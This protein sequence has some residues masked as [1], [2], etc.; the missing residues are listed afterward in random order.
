[1]LLQEKAAIGFKLESTIGLKQVTGAED[2][3]V[4]NM[5]RVMGFDSYLSYILCYT[6]FQQVQRLDIVSISSI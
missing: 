3:S 4:S 5:G 6:K 2:K 1:M